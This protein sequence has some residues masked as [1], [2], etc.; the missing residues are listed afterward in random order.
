M[1][2]GGHP[3]CRELDL[4]QAADVGS[5]E[6]GDCLANGHATRRRPIDQG[7]RRALAHRKGFTNK[8]VETHCRHGHISHR[9]LPRPDHLVA[10][11]H[12]ANAAVTNGDQKVLR[13]HAGQAQ[14]A[15]RRFLQL[16]RFNVQCRQ[17]GL[18]ASGVAMHAR[19]LTQQHFHWH[20]DGQIAEVII[21][22]LQHAPFG[23]F[24]DNSKRATLAFAHG[25]KIIKPLWRD[26]QHIALLRFVAPDFA[27]RHAGLF[28][29]QCTQVK[30][31]TT[32]GAI[33][34][35][36]HGIGDAAGAN[37]VN[38]EYWVG[39]AQLPAAIDDFLRAPLNLRVAAL[40]RSEIE[41]GGIAARRH[42]RRRTTAQSDQ[43]AGSAKLD[44]QGAGRKF[45][46]E[47]VACGNVA[48]AAGNHDR[49]VIAAHFSANLLLERAEITREVGPAEFVVESR[50]PDRPF[51]H[52]VKRRR[53][54]VR[55]AIG[56]LP[57]LPVVG[58]AQ[59]GNRKAAQPS[60]GL[61]TAPGRAL[62][63]NLAAGTG[64]GPRKR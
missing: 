50:R 16:D 36:G 53:D 63:A 38:C 8:G 32:P 14:D 47:R 28:G 56:R 51:D 27:R 1:T 23:R 45:D 44:Q 6:I 22:H 52:D 39:L 54:A 21:L 10:C 64:G 4:A 62:V 31:R 61:G 19:R 33:G 26:R 37:I 55:L 59:V 43:H 24:A 57:R 20:V 17:L 11:C 13:G 58:N 42:R 7:Q 29:R 15:P 30:L 5:R 46:L 25:A 35:F 40:H 48:N 12:A 2:G 18:Y 9:H 41:I 34:Q 3:V 49:L 60:L